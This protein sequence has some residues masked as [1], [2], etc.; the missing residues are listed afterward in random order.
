MVGAQKIGS[1]ISSPRIAGLKIT[2]HEAVSENCDLA[3]G[4][5]VTAM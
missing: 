4:G 2:E 5:S 1:A 3:G